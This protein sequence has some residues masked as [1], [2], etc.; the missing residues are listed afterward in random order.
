MADN[1]Q[2]YICLCAMLRAREP[3]MLTNEKAALCCDAQSFEDA[4]RIIGECGFADMS[5]LDIEGVNKAVS[6]HLEGIYEEVRR[7]SPGTEAVDIFSA[8]YDYHNAKTLIKGEA[9][10]ADQA[11]LYVCLG[12][13]FPEKLVYAYTEDNYRD[14]PPAMTEAIKKAKEIIGRSGN[15]QQADFVLDKA[16]YKEI[17][18]LA[19]ASGSG[20]LVKYVKLLIDAANLKTLVRALKLGKPRDFIAEA[21]IEG[22]NAEPYR[23]ITI[24]DGDQL[25]AFF[26][27]EVLSKAAALGKEVV[28]GEKMTGFELAIDNAVN[29]YLKDTRLI[30]YGPE[31]VAEYLA[32]V[33]SE[34]TA[35]RMIL[36]CKLAGVK[37]DTIKER[38]RDLYA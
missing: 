25:E 12:R 18:D 1:K 13:V 15:P 2:K 7:L 34:S 30:T 14:V 26:E 20:F 24:T 16:Y 3:L 8:K 32:A 5:G 23:L 38:L 19:V 29:N 9:A 21:L 6:D 36:T 27:G 28:A 4:A 11:G 10:G 22:G 17:L 35:V 31:V 37:A 33:E